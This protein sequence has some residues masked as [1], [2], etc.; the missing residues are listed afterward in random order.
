MAYFTQFSQ[1][2]AVKNPNDINASNLNLDS[3]ISILPK[4]HSVNQSDL[5]QVRDSLIRDQS[6]M[7]YYAP[8]HTTIGG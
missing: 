7:S 4:T 2:S 3:V 5:L 8:I 1:K 6:Q